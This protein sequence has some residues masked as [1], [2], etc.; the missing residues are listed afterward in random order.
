MFIDRAILN[1]LNKDIFGGGLIQTKKIRPDYGK[2]VMP[3]PRL[4]R[5]KRYQFTSN[6]P[7]GQ[8]QGVMTGQIVAGPQTQMPPEPIS[9]QVQA[10]PTQI[11]EA[12]VEEKPI[13]APPTAEPEPVKTEETPAAAE[14]APAE[15]PAPAQAAGAFTIKGAG[16]G[17][18]KVPANYSS[19]DQTEIKL[20]DLLNEEPS[21]FEVAVDS[22][23]CKVYKRPVSFYFIY[24]Y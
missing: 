18:V 20:I 24:F 5:I 2:L 16:D 13:T 23:N 4:P 12:P 10:P 6:N 8:L 14:P 7:L 1:Q 3:D 9:Q 21:N 15:T 11:S 22:A 19:D 17:T